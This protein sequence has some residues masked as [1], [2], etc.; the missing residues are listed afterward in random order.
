VR[1]QHGLAPLNAGPHTVSETAGIGTILANYATLIGGDR[2]GERTI[3]P[4]IFG[5][6]RSAPS[7]REARTIVITKVAVPQ[8]PQDFS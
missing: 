2:A 1:R 4:A 5:R 8:S 7:Q 6:E 3:T